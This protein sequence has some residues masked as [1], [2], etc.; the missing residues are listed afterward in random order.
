MKRLPKPGKPSALFP[1]RRAVNEV[2]GTPQSIND[3]GKRVK[4]L[5]GDPALEI[6]R[7]YGKRGTQTGG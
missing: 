3:Y 4:L 7:Q 6:E 5:S 1:S 2:L